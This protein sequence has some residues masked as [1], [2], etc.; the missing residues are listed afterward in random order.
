MIEQFPLKVW[1]LLHGRS[2]LHGRCICSLGYFSF[3]PVVHNWSIK[4]YGMCCP[5]SWK[6]HIK[7]SLL[8][9]GKSILCCDSG[10]PLKRYVTMTICLTSESRWYENQCAL[11]ASLNKTNVP[12]QSFMKRQQNSEYTC[13]KHNK[14]SSE[15]DPTS[16]RWL[17][18]PNDHNFRKR[19][20]S[21][22]K[23]DVLVIVI[24][25]NVVAYS[26]IHTSTLSRT[27]WGELKCS[28]GRSSEAD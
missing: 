24:F 15:E 2:I 11:K 14:C 5:V 4:C 8:L 16:S 20:L 22:C 1:I 13:I 26:P 23:S 10:F 21:Q 25:C 3:Q 12:L 19:V 18:Q 28:C 7:D 6:V 17:G 27:S 9:I